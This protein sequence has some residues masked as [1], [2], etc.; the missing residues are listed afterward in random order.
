MLCSLWDEILWD[1]DQT[2]LT[3]LSCLIVALLIVLVCLDLSLKEMNQLHLYSLCF[4]DGGSEFM[5]RVYM[6]LLRSCI[7]W[8]MTL[9]TISISLIVYLVF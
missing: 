7:G 6:L 9:G 4:C 2:E 1:H 8:L 5:P 3:R